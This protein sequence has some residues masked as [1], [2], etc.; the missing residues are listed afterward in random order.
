VNKF[1]PMK[2]PFRFSAT[3]DIF[4]LNRINPSLSFGKQN[5]HDIYEQFIQTV[6]DK[7]P[8]RKEAI[9]CRLGALIASL[10]NNTLKVNG[11]PSIF[12]KKL[13]L[14]NGLSHLLDKENVPKDQKPTKRR[15]GEPLND[16]KRVTLNTIARNSRAQTTKLDS[17]DAQKLLE[18]RIKL[19]QDQL[20]YQQKKLVIEN[21]QKVRKDS[22]DVQK[23]RKD[24]ADAQKVWESKI[25]LA[26]KDVQKVWESNIKQAQEDA[27]KFWESKVKLAQEDAQKLWESNIKL[28]QEQLEYQ[29][30]RL[31]QLADRLNPKIKSVAS[32]TIW[33][34][35]KSK[36]HAREFYE[37]ILGINI[38][39][40]PYS[41]C[42]FKLQLPGLTVLVKAGVQKSSIVLNVSDLHHW[43][44]K[45]NVKGLKPDVSYPEKRVSFEDPFGNFWH[46]VT[47]EY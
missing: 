35:A 31:D 2:K 34:P 10:Q 30:K 28:A 12:A 18:S 29:Q 42:M 23:V 9:K 4:I 6:P 13:Q 15:L 1:D 47:D 26:Q 46:M 5:Y 24:S 38:A 39:D 32:I 44:M 22:A 45:I 11:P 40:G 36:N 41:E 8:P 37:M 21:V 27:Q 16:P 19:A 20:E 7:D 43:A 33:V 25:K 17:T 3:D 14:L